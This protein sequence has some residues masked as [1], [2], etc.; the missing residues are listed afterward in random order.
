MDPISRSAYAF[1][2]GERGAV[3]IQ[4]DR[5]PWRCEAMT[6]SGFTMASVVRQLLHVRDSHAQNHR[7]A[8]ALHRALAVSNIRSR[9]HRTHTSADH[10]HVWRRAPKWNPALSMSRFMRSTGWT[11]AR[12][13]FPLTRRMPFSTTI[14]AWT[15]HTSRG[16]E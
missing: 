4:N 15:Y 12:N 7:S 9:A 2:H 10:C 14:A 3:R 6:V 1:C 8:F 13:G 11:K 5:K 16:Y